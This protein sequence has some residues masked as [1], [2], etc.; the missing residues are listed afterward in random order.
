MRESIQV[1]PA[2]VDVSPPYNGDGVPFDSIDETPKTEKA[3]KA[4]AATEAETVIEEEIKFGHKIGTENSSSSPSDA[5]T[6]ASFSSLPPTNTLVPVPAEENSTPIE[7][8]DA[9]TAE[10][11]TTTS[12][13]TFTP[14]AEETT[15]GFTQKF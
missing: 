4:A 11:T 5:V 15:T 1:V 10:S 7:Q 2:A 13:A 9:R 8:T 12:P 14:E 6:D 3:S